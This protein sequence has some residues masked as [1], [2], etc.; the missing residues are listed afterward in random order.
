MNKTKGNVYE[1]CAINKKGI[2]E[3]FSVFSDKDIIKED[4]GGIIEER[5]E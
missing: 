1:A 4:H 3:N 2:Q 5:K